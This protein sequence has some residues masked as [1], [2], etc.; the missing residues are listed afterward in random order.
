ML[1]VTAGDNKLVRDRQELLFSKDDWFSVQ[2]HR[3]KSMLDEIASYDGNKLLNTS[4]ED[5]VIYF[6]GRYEVEVP[7]L[8]ET[9]IVAEQSET[10][11]DVSNDPRRYIRDRSGPFYVPG[12]QITLTI[13]YAGD[14]HLFYVQPTTFNYNPPRAIVQGHSLILVVTGT[15][16]NSESVKSSIDRSI[17]D[18]NTWLK[19]LRTNGSQFNQSLPEQAR[20]AIEQRRKKLLENQSLVSSLGFKLKERSGAPKTYVT[21][22]V[23]RKI[24]PTPPPASTEPFQPEPA[25]EL[26]EYE[27]ILGILN[28]MVHVMERS[29]SA[30]RGMDEEA[31]R[32]HFLVQLNGQYEG[33]ATGETFNGAGKT[34]ILL[35]VDGKNVFIGECKFWGGPKILLATIEQLLSYSSWRDTKVA[36]LI[37]NTRKNFSAVLEAI[38]ET[39]AQHACYKRTVAAA[40]ESNFRFVMSHKDDV[41]REMTMSVLAYDIPTE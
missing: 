17:S 21:P 9:E 33:G 22:E 14:S 25:I 7:S 4:L 40:G 35:R 32:T 34:D 15:D 38:P 31:L 29:P 5:L 26:A 3:R 20:Q 16:L 23:R 12:T 18:I 24:R 36:V 8:V 39:V 13:P 19:N 27:H 30:F 11:I 37:F 41:N 28:N 1:G 2:E 6:V 10:Q